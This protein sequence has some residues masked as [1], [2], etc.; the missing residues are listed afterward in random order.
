ME[1]KYVEEN[2]I[3]IEKLPLRRDI[4]INTIIAMVVK[5]ILRYLLMAAYIMACNEFGLYNYGFIA[6][7]VVTLTSICV[8]RWIMREIGVIIYGDSMD[9]EAF[10]TVGIIH[11]IRGISRMIKR[12]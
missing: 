6:K 11:C 1:S 7:I 4:V 5:C 8:S 3:E 10:E 9:D 2:K 12:L